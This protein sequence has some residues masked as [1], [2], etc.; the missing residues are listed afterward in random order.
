MKDLF[1]GICGKSVT[2]SS[3]CLEHD[4]GTLAVKMQCV[5]EDGEP[6][7]VI[8][9]NVSKLKLSDISY[10]FQVGGFEIADNS[11]R[12]YQKDCRFFVS[13]YEDDTLSFYCESAEVFA[14][15]EASGD[16]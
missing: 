12:A 15:D 14:E 8:F 13:D 9:Q 11:A 5:S 1:S 6:Y 4:E 2:V 7:F 10:P 3:F 16:E